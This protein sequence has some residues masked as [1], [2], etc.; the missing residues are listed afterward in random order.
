VKTKPNAGNCGCTPV[1][2]TGD[3]FSTP[4]IKTFPA[5]DAESTIAQYVIVFDPD[6]QS[7][8]CTKFVFETVAPE[9]VRSVDLET[10]TLAYEP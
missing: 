1:L 7:G 9:T 8:N 4:L 5:P 6:V 3:E 2:I 10:A